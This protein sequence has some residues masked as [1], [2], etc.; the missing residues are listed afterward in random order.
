MTRMVVRSSGLLQLRMRPNN[1]L[2]VVHYPLFGLV[3]QER[4]GVYAGRNQR[5][6]T[7]LLVVPMVAE[8]VTA[9]ILAERSAAGP[10]RAL[11]W[12]GLVLLAVIWLSTAVLQFP[13]HLRL[14]RGFDARVQRQL[15][16]SN[17][18]RTMAWTARG[19]IA[20]VMIAPC[21]AA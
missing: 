14:R 11:A 10:G 17:W 5:L 20:M 18:V 7:R 3:G 2:Q 15:V 6:T 16:L 8:L 13:Q 1:P 12:A 4:I 19:I 21:L 9:I